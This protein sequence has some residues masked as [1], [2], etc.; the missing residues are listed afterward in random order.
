MKTKIKKIS[1]FIVLIWL[2]WTTANVEAATQVWEGTVT[3][4]WTLTTPIMWNDLF[5]WTAS[6]TIDGII[7]TAQVLPILNMVIS[8][9]S[10]ALGT[11]NNTTY[12]SGSIDIEVGTNASTGVNITARSKNGWL[13]SATNSSIINDL[14]TDGIAESYKFNSTLNASSDSTVIW[15]TQTANLDTEVDSSGTNHSIYSTNKPEESDGINDVK[16][17][18]AAKVSTQ[19]PAGNDYKDTIVFSIT[20]NF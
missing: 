6:G 4:S 19:T 15:Y 8:A 14:T 16:F 1:A 18:V 20:W 17:S 3:G 2:L 13:S 11:L 9:D 5:P 10:I 12:S 7:V